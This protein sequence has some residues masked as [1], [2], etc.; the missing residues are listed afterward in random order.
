[1]VGNRESLSLPRLVAWRR[2]SPRCLFLWMHLGQ[3]NEMERATDSRLPLCC[4]NMLIGKDQRERF[5]HCQSH[6]KWNQA[7]QSMR[8]GFSSL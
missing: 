4:C 3:Q 5:I 7:P 8:Y 2:A 6:L 1:M